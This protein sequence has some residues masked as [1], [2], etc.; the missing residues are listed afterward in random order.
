MSFKASVGRNGYLGRLY[1]IAKEL[2]FDMRFTQKGLERTL[3]LDSPPMM[4]T[5]IAGNDRGQLQLF[6]Q[7]PEIEIQ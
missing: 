1:R 6:L 2:N 5:Q 4:I 3:I 7:N